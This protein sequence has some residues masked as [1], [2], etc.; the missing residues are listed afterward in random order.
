M[1]LIY[2]VDAFVLLATG[3]AAKRRPAELVEVVAAIEMI[4]GAM[5]GE[6]R[7]SESFTRLAS[8]GLLIAEEGRYTLTPAAEA[9]MAVPKKKADAEARVAYLKEVLAEY[10]PIDEPEEGFA[11]LEVTPAQL[12]A[13]M[14]AHRLS[15]KDTGIAML[16][17][18][19]KTE[20]DYT[21]S[22]P[23]KP[24]GK[25]GSFAKRK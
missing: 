3:I 1:R 7:M 23:W 8:W 19:K 5:P 22:G 17:P 6:Y 11:P 9:I 12:V 24:R 21:R 2:D 14:K 18:K 13:A 4:H 16:M 20:V 15:A 10:E 25:S